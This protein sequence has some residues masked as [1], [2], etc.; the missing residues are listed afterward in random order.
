[1]ASQS[2]IGTLRREYLDHTLFWTTADLENKLLDFRTYFN[3]HCT[4]TSR[5]GRTPDTPASRPAA[6][7]HSFRWQPHCRALYQTPMAARFLKDSRSL[8]YPVD[9]CKNLEGNH[10]VFA[11]LVAARFAALIVSLPPYQFARDSRGRMTLHRAIDRNPSR[12]DT[13]EQR[14]AGSMR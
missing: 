7:L 5:E 13:T 3:N 6:N 2:T 1:M 4:H 11:F 12:S 8:R 9:L 14:L 10:P